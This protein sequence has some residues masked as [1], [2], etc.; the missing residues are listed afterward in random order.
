MSTSGL[1]HAPILTTAVQV[2]GRSTVLWVVIEQYSSAALSPFYPWMVLAWSAA[3]TIRY[4]YFA[5]RLV[6][7]HQYQ[8]LTWLRYSAF[9]VLYPIGIAS[10][11][12]VVYN[13]ISDAFALGYDGHAWGYIAAATLYLPGRCPILLV[14]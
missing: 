11:I 14:H 10:E 4:L 13:A 12:G 8:N 9:Y 2:A 5:T 6:G 7:G 3:D 1:V